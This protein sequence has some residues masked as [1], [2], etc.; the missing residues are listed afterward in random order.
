MEKLIKIFVN[1]LKKNSK[2]FFLFTALFLIVF[3][4]EDRLRKTKE[5]KYN[6]YLVLT[7]P[8]ASD[9]V[10][11]NQ[12]RFK[13]DFYHYVITKDTKDKIKKLCE[14]SQ[15][16]QQ[17]DMNFTQNGFNYLKIDLYHMKL[18]QDGCLNSVF[19]EV[20][21]NYFN[22]YIKKVINDN[23]ILLGF[24]KQEEELNLNANLYLSTLETSFLPP[25]I[26]DMGLN[27]K[28]TVGI[29]HIKTIIVSIIFSI[30]LTLFFSNLILNK[31]KNNL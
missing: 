10:S 4:G 29:N 31:K 17:N 24:L 21:Q 28:I 7:Q 25:Q 23:K 26:I 19:D 6:S 9:W 27:N 3:Y 16:K 12:N 5:F 20:I 11:F 8:T 1:D 2:Y 30:I 13:R 18:A 22:D 14:V 15:S